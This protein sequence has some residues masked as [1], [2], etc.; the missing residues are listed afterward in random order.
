MRGSNALHPSW[1]AATTSHRRSLRWLF[2]PEPPSTPSDVAAPPPDLPAT[3]SPAEPPA[4]SDAP[5]DDRSAEDGAAP[6]PTPEPNASSVTA[7]EP[8][9]RPH[10][11]RFAVALQV[12]RGF[13]DVVAL[14]RACAEHAPRSVAR[15]A[16][17]SLARHILRGARDRSR[18][19][20][21]RP[22][23]DHQRRTRSLREPRPPRLRPAFPKKRTRRRRASATA[24][25]PA[26]TTNLSAA[27]KPSA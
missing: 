26:P 10:R 13:S 4:K 11:T 25:T 16:S 14:V 24:V 5:A 21:L 12:G 7:A 18:D 17:L 22:L 2:P 6:A 1:P 27:A 9:P 20:H 15:T 3:T 23:L 19:R 8:A